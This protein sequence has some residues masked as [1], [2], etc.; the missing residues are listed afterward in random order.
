MDVSNL[1]WVEVLSY[2]G[3]SQAAYRLDAAGGRV[4]LSVDGLQWP[5]AGR[6]AKFRSRIRPHGLAAKRK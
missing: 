5:K 2:L 3:G 4:R 6:K 1:S